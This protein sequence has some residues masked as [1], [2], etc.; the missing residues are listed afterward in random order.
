MS[1]Y[2]KPRKVEKLARLE[3]PCLAVCAGKHCAK[4][5]TKHILRAVHAALDDAGLDSSVQVALTKCQ[6]YCDYGPVVTVLPG[7]YPY[8]GLTPQSVQ[9]VVQEHLGQERPVVSL[10]YKRMRKRLQG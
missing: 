7:E 9:Q 3:R 6:D 1:K 4:A 2:D 10:L 8:V 5:G